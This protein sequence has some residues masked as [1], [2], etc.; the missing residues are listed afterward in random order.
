MYDWDIYDASSKNGSECA[1]NIAMITADIERIIRVNDTARTN[2]TN[3]LNGKGYH[4]FFPEIGDY[5]YYIADIW[6]TGAQYGHRVAMCNMVL[7]EEWKTDP[8]KLLR[9]FSWNTVGVF[10]DGYDASSNIG[11]LPVR[12]DLFIR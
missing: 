12:T 1:V 10:I 7:S 11:N 6:A 3:A 5:M 2:L 4:G 8:I 9:D